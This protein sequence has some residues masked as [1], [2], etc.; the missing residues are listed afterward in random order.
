MFNEQV[1]FFELFNNLFV[2]TS[3]Q[4]K[5][6]LFFIQKEM[7]LTMELIQKSHDIN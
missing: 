7:F 1:G 6:S 5:D 2:H 3:K 4:R